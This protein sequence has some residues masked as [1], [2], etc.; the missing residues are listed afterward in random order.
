MINRNR[1]I[2]R[3]N[4]NYYVLNENSKEDVT[5]SVALNYQLSV[6]GKFTITPTPDIIVA[7]MNKINTETK[8]IFLPNIINSQ[9]IEIMS[10]KITTIASLGFVTQNQRYS[11]AILNDRID[12]NYNKADDS[13]I[14]IETFYDFSVKVLSAVMDYFGIASNRLAINIQQVCEFGSFEDLRMCGKKL[15]VAAAYYNDKEFS[16]WSMRT[17]SQVNIPLG[18][19]Q[20][21]VNVITDISSGQDMT[22]QKAACLFH[23]D[24]NTAPQNQSMRF[25]KDSLLSFVQSAET[26]AVKLIGDV[27][28]L[29]GNDK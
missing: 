2:F 3:I 26:I 22:G 28:R 17:N 6:F 25:N 13:N 7:L 18:E 15:V 16:E 10:N 23:I 1:Y 12:V 24:I 8:E 27:E 21:V 9:Q 14:D 11:I 20:E 4:K 5:I 19:Q 29:V